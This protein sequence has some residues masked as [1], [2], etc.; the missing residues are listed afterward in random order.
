L[1]TRGYPSS[2]NR[3]PGPRNMTDIANGMAVI[4]AASSR[5]LP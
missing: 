3:C 5:Y 4:E 1:K 2:G